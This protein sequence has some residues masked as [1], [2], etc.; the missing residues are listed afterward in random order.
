MEVGIGLFG[1]WL[2]EV[3]YGRIGTPGRRLCYVASDEAEARNLVH[4]TL[5]RLATVTR[6]SGT[7]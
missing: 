7:T 5:R 2:V 6:H 1:A 3:T 4:K